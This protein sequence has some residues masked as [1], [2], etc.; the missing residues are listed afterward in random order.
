VVLSRSVWNGLLAALGAILL[1]TSCVGRAQP[2]PAPPTEGPSEEVHRAAGGT[3]PGLTAP[4]I[5]LTAEPRWDGSFAMTEAVVLR[6]ATDTVPLT[7]PDVEAGLP[8]LRGTEPLVVSFSAVADGEPVVLAPAQVDSATALP[9]FTAV[10]HLV[11]RYRLTGTTIRSTP[12]GPL[13][14]LAL[15]APL[16]A[17]ADGTLPTNVVVV[18]GAGLRNAYCPRLR[19]PR[20]AV[21][22]YP[23][24][25]VRPQIPAEL[26]VVVLQLDLP[27]AP[28]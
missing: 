6:N 15:L 2:E 23:V 22:A 7:L 12:S 19:E 13:R 27:A 1:L 21:G 26:A 4:G 3:G 11:L 5:R 25:S 9:L 14:A 24:L 8:A 10:S 16:T 28:K 18:A 17:T 20:C